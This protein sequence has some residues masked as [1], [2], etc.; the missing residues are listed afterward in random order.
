MAKNVIPIRAS[1]EEHSRWKQAAGTQTFSAWARQMLN[2]AADAEEAERLEKE[3]PRRQRE[4]MLAKLTPGVN[5]EPIP[6][7]PG[8][9][10]RGGP[11]PK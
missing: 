5:R 3:A 1:A 4:E 6:A 2:E 7:F 10:R 9:R 11:D 8:G